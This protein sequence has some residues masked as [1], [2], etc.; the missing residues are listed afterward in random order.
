MKV[1]NYVVVNVLVLFVVIV[2]I[3]DIAY[4]YLNY[5]FNSDQ[6]LVFVVFII[7]LLRRKF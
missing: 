3:W 5:E 7:T 1:K 6:V 2:I 4:M